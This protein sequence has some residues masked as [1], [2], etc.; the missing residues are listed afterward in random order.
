LAVSRALLSA[1]AA[2]TL[3]LAAPA[4]ATATE[5][6]SRYDADGE[7]HADRCVA[8]K[9]ADVPLRYLSA[10]PTG[11]AI[12]NPLSYTD[13]S[14]PTGQLRIDL[15]EVVASPAGPL[16]FARGGNGYT[17]G[18]N[19]KYG[20]VLLSDL[21]TDPGAPTPAGGGRGDACLALL[22]STYEAQIES[23]PAVMHYKPPP[24]G[25]SNNG[26]SFEHY[27]DPAADQGDRHD[28]HYSYLLWSFLNA[29]G[30]GHVRALLHPDQDVEPC[31]VDP[32]VMDAWDG[33]G[34]VNGSVLA[35]YV[36]TEEGGTPLYG[37]MVWEHRSGAGPVVEHEHLVSGPQ[38]TTPPGLPVS[39]PVT[40]T[41]RSEHGPT[42]A[43][44]AT[45]AAAPTPPPAPPPAPA[46]V[47]LRALV[48]LAKA[49][50]DGRGAVRVPLDCTGTAAGACTGTLRL[51]AALPAKPGAHTAAAHFSTLAR[52]GFS[53]GAGTSAV[54]TLRVRAALRRR[55]PR[56]RGVRARLVLSTGSTHSLRLVRR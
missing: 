23:I 25:G 55:L 26:S 51:D 43:A 24:P 27:G 19:A 52:R 38:V 47:P 50:V 21:A 32:I 10:E 29:H 1:A 37:W 8:P 49:V 33:A 16:A 9:T 20:Q 39:P 36:R 18:Q 11:F 35:R 28:I 41:A 42:P 46:P 5:P 44:L 6:A 14:C 45:A 34:N 15:H 4:A 31:D 22:G 12:P 48:G 40:N 53:V 56:G 3:A 2:A 17:D 30:G 7:R 13:G 54:V